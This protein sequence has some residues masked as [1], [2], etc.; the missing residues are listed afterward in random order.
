MNL[1][2][3]FDPTY[4]DQNKIDSYGKLERL[5]AAVAAGAEHSGS[6]GGPPTLDPT[7]VVAGLGEI[8]RGSDKEGERP[9]QPD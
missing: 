2:S 9:D 7:A 6:A 4:G 3:S 8:E 1:T 5:S